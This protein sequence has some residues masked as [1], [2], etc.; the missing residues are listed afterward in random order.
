MLLNEI[1]ELFGW[2]V[3]GGIAFYLFLYIFISFV[4]SITNEQLQSLYND[5][6]NLYLKTENIKTELRMLKEEVTLLKEDKGHLQDAR[7]F[8]VLGRVID[9]EKSLKKVKGGK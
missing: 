8:S 1:V 6:N 9:L 4:K 3:L 2:L 7:Y 5:R